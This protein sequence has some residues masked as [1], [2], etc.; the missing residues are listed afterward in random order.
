MN[1]EKMKSVLSKVLSREEMKQVMAGS[2][3]GHVCG[4]CFGPVGSGACYSVG[5]LCEGCGR[6]C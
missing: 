6:L 4:G 2:D 1:L 5:G 3:D